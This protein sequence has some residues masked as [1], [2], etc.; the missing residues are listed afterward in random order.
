[1]HAPEPG[2]AVV[3]PVRGGPL[4]KSR[5]DLPV[6]TR[7]VLADAFAHDTIAALLGA[8]SVARVLVVTGDAEVDA[9]VHESDATSVPDPVSASRPSSPFSASF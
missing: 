2:W 5:L 3:V 7:G 9:W 8:Q 1:M 6:G 4:A